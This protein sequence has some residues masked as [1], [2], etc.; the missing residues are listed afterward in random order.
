MSGKHHCW[1]LLLLNSLWGIILCSA[2]NLCFQ[3]SD[4]N[5]EVHYGAFFNNPRVLQDDSRGNE[6]QPPCD[7]GRNARFQICRDPCYTLNVTTHVTWLF[8]VCS[9][10]QQNPIQHIL[11]KTT[12]P[13]PLQTKYCFCT[14][15][16][17]NLIRSASTMMRIGASRLKEQHTALVTRSHTDLLGTSYY[18]K[19]KRRRLYIQQL[20]IVFIEL[21]YLKLNYTKYYM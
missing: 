8:N 19:M 12:P 6:R 5:I 2:Q 15:D 4:P 9:S 17:C 14:G 7:S 20:C 13:H 10:I 11:L 21:N 1:A 3:C 16:T 18:L